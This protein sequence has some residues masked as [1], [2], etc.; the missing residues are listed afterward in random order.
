M[1]TQGKGTYQITGWDEK[2][3]SER[4]GDAKL[5]Q[6]HVTNTFTGDVEGDGKAE[7]LMV[8][9]SETYATF[10]GHQWVSGSV[11]GRKGSFVLQAV[12]SFENGKAKADWSVVPGS[13]TQELEG[14]EGSGGYVSTSD[15][16]SEFTLKYTLR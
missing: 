16:G 12:G 5:T 14:L 1:S 6:A 8:Y 13:G 2:P 7:Y 15:G 11:G 3:Y 9:P 10:V 4:K